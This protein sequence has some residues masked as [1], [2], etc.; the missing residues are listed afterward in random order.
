M[1]EKLYTQE[2]VDALHREWDSDLFASK[3]DAALERIDKRLDTSN[4]YKETFG[5]DLTDIKFAQKDIQVRLF[6][7]ENDRLKEQQIAAEAKKN[8]DKWYQDRWIRAGIAGGLI[9]EAWT[10]F[11]EPIKTAAH[12]LGWG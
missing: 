4:A 7:L 1:T 5:K 8:K 10:M 6:A 12:H 11:G 3:T 2:E 9:W